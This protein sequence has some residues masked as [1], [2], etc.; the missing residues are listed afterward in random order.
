MSA[1]RMMCVV[2][3]LLWVEAG[4]ERTEKADPGF[5]LGLLSIRLGLVGTVAYYK[6]L[7]SQLSQM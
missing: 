1:L 3:G 7:T 6:Y 2:L 5:S 4:P